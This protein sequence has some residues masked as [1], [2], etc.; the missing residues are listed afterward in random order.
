MQHF[1][2]AVIKL[3]IADNTCFE[4]VV[5]AV[6]FQGAHLLVECARA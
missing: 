2:K 5:L 6:I 4:L 3:N 1:F